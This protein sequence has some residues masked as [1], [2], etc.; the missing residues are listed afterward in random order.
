MTHERAI[1][2][3]IENAGIQFDPHIVEVFIN[4]PRE[5]LTKHAAASAIENQV[6]QLAGAATG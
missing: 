3:L 1:S 6:E 5:V 4:L 2:I